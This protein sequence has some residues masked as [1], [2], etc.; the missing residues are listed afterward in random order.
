MLLKNRFPV[1][2]IIIPMRNEENYI[3][4]C[5]KSLI[6][7]DCPEDSYEVI[8]VDGMS[9]DRSRE[10]VRSLSNN[11]SNVF[12]LE[13]PNIV[14]S[15]GL[16]IGIKKSRGKIVNILGAH[17]FVRADFIKENIETFENVE[18]DCV[19]GPIQSVG[20]TYSAR[21]ISLAMSS[22]FGIGNALFRYSTRDGYVDTLAFGAY[23]R[24]VF[25]KIGLF[26]EELVRNQDD[27]FNYRLRKAGGK[28]FITPRI[29]S[30]Y[31]NQA[32]LKKVWRQYFQY[33]FWKVRVMQK[34]LKMMK[35][36]QFIPTVFVLSIIISLLLS[37]HSKIFLVSFL[38]ISG[39]YLA[40]NLF[41]S[42]RIARKYEWKYFFF[43]PL[44]FNTLHWSYGF[45]FLIGLFRFFHRWFIK[46]RNDC[47]VSFLQN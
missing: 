33:G 32:T 14:T 25:R 4:K 30:F 40:C 26:D 31:Y 43:L 28:I 24:E 42:F 27:E 16:N 21:A 7:Q 35:L 8:I 10:I 37:F 44:V 3:E 12:L 17:S 22:P 45:G 1:I 41:F 34:H 15:F 20:K 18:A 5:V 2:S 6:D 47:S 23:K 46:T 13:N 36:R 38:L 39:I 9:D 11:H 29:R 19:G